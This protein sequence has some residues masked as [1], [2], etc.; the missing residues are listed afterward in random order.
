MIQLTRWREGDL[1]GWQTI[2]GRFRIVKTGKV[3]QTTDLGWEFNFENHATLAEARRA[4]VKTLGL[5][6]IY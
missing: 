1:V 4:L 2:D 6:V 5:E 3:W